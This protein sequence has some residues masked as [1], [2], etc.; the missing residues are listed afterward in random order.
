MVARARLFYTQKKFDETELMA[1]RAIE[2]KHD[3]DGSWNILGRALLSQGKYEG[4]AN[5]RK[6]RW[7]PTE[8]TTILIFRIVDP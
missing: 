8:T 6:K 1:R 5:L 7:T 2:R 3:C 4:A